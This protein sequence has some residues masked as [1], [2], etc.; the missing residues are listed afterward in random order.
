MTLDEI[1]AQI[2]FYTN[3]N[4]TTF[5]DTDKDREAN[6]ANR[7]IM[8]EIMAIE[9]SK[10]LLGAEK[11]TSLVA[12]DGLSAGDN[13]YN[14]EYAFDSD[15]MRIVRV[16]IKY[17]STG[18]PYPAEIYD[19]SENSSS[20]Y[21]E[22]SIQAEF[23]ESS[24]M[25]MIFRNAYRVRP[26]YTEGDDI[27]GGIHIWYEKRLDDLSDASDTPEFEELFHNL[28]PL[29]VAK[30]YSLK[31]PQRYDYKWLRGITEEYQD[32][33]RNF[34]QYYRKQVV[35]KKQMIPSRHNFK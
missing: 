14:G 25:I 19:M 27:T 17:S 12:T 35:I 11:Y 24:P 1:R 22:D 21:D 9:G 8:A 23:S 18:T 30:L 13:G 15:M 5:P 34:R 29:K 7:Q 16:E 33:Y 4:S 32:V 3:T 26:L 28:I 6:N 10:N 20:E 31:Y 2:E